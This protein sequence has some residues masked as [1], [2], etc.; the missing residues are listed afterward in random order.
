[1]KLESADKFIFIP[2]SV[3]QAI[4]LLA[5]C[6]REGY[7]GEILQFRLPRAQISVVFDGFLAIFGVFGSAVSLRQGLSDNLLVNRTAA[8]LS[9]SHVVATS[10][11][12]RGALPKGSKRRV[13]PWRHKPLF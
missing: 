8:I 2:I 1:M 7:L 3:W 6:R 12:R 5:G 10:L 11:K 4:Y 9:M 13:A